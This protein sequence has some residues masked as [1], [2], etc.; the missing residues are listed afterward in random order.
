MLEKIPPQGGLS[1]KHISATQLADLGEYQYSSGQEREVYLKRL[2]GPDAGDD[3]AAAPDSGSIGRRT[4]SARSRG[5]IVHDLLRFGDFDA[6]DEF[7]RALA[8]QRGLTT[9]RSIDLA[10]DEVKRLL[11]DFRQSKVFRWI[12]SARAERRPVYTELPFV[13]RANGRIIHGVMDL[14][15]QQ[16]DG[17]WAIV[18]YKTTEIIGSPE[19]HVQRYYLQL[20]V[21]AA[22]AQAHLGLPDPRQ[23]SFITWLKAVLCQSK[24]ITASRSSG[25]SKR[26]W[27]NWNNSMPERWKTLL[28]YWARPEHPILQ[29]ELANLRLGGSRW[30][31]IIQLLLL[32]L[33]LGGGGY[34]YAGSTSTDTG[35]GNLAD[36]IWR[37]LYFPSIL[38][39]TATVLSALAFGI[40]SVEIDRS[41]QTWDSLRVTEI[42][43]GLTL[44]T[45]WVAIF[46]RL[47][48]PILALLMA[49]LFLVL[50]MIVDMTAFGGG[51]LRVLG[52]TLVDSGYSW[53]IT[54]P[55][56]ALL[57][58]AN[59]LLPLTTVGAASALGILISVAI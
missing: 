36:F 24:E 51:Y 28:P 44:R 17:S 49:R 29:Y 40:G 5:A 55:M 34:L 22:A 25:N 27:A 15:L 53:W 10:V 47:R 32:A 48:A 16:A 52:S 7:M 31:S 13:F 38:V 6:T 56:I 35:A 8:W 50:G 45:R 30:K 19:T 39:Q 2:L 3:R 54:L 46:Y 1:L 37:C 33:L 14:L 11:S 57:M 59:L 21:Y 4:L 23:R 58:T 20:A 26:A 12:K 42:G 9:N 41:R 43:A 18:D